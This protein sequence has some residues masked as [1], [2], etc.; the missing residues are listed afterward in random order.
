[1]IYDSENIDKLTENFVLD[2]NN[3]VQWNPGNDL[4]SYYSKL[5]VMLSVWEDDYITSV[6][7][8]IERLHVEV[9]KA[10]SKIDRLNILEN[11]ILET[12]NKDLIER[13]IDRNFDGIYPTSIS[14]NSKLR[15]EEAQEYK[16]LIKSDH[17]KRIEL[18]KVNI[19]KKHA[20]LK[21]R[22]EKVMDYNSL[23]D[24]ELKVP[25]IYRGY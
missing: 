2:T 23:D 15:L 12:G 7:D 18:V 10:Q 1:M 11:L 22:K 14:Y 24:Y 25:P 8:E 9:D 19:S 17:N 5:G 16:T 6:E 4:N 3:G 21:M 20:N 13:V